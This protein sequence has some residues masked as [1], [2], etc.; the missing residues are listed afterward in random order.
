MKWFQKLAFARKV[1]G[2]TLEQV[3]S[4]GHISK[5]YLCEIEKGRIGDPSFFKI[6]GLLRLYNLTPDD[7]KSDI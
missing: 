2:W 7:I 5:A 3:A 6:S 4:T 1:K